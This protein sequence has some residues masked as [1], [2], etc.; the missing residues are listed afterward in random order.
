[1]ELRKIKM[2]YYEENAQT[3]Y[4]KTKDADMTDSCNRFAKYI[5][6]AGRILDIGCGSGR[7]MKYFKSL[8]FSPEG[9]EPSKGLWELAEK[10]T[11]LPVHC[12]TLQAYR[13]SAPY[14]GIWA[15]ASLLHLTEE[16]ILEFFKRSCEFTAP[17][18][19]IYFSGKNGIETGVSE[20]GRFFL[21]FTDE[22]IEKILRENENLELVEKWYSED[23]TGRKDFRWMN[24]ILKNVME[25]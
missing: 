25:I 7:D 1:M 11:G 18:G 10:N 19:Y 17:G 16:E 15:C 9:L 2:N 8:G 20:D 3:Y 4:N 22:L 23:V 5:R 21:E 6:P 12:I 13:P 24:V 14:D